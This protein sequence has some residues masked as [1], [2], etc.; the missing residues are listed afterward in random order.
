MRIPNVGIWLGFEEKEALNFALKTKHNK[1]KQANP[2]PVTYYDTRSGN[3][4]APIHSVYQ[5][6]APQGALRT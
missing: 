2:D 6:Q 4:V 5:A 1:H 3:E